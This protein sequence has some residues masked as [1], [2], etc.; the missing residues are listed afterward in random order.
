MNTFLA[1]PAAPVLMVLI[2]SLGTQ[3]AAVIV[4]D[5]LA[6]VGAPGVS[7]LRMAAAA[8]IM[9]ALF[10]PKL[11]GMTRARAINIVVYGVAMGMMSMM[12]YA[13]IA[14]LPQG[15]AVTIDFLGP[16]SCRFSA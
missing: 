12:V 14:R 13:A 1:L 9:V 16:A 8:V 15:V 3:A 11:T 7:G 10:R 5:M 4:T 6:T 2:G